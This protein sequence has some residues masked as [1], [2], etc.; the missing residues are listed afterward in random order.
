MNRHFA[1]IFLTLFA[2]ALASC[3]GGKSIVPPP[4]DRN[5][6]GVVTDSQGR[7]VPGLS[8]LIDGQATGITTSASGEFQLSSAAFAKGMDS[9]YRMA[10][11]KGGVVFSESFMTPSQNGNLE[12]R[13][14]PSSGGSGLLAGS[15][16]NQSTFSVLS[17][18]L[19]I[20]FANE[21]G[22][23]YSSTDGSGAYS[24]E[25][26]A[27]QW[28][29]LAWKNGYNPGVTTVEVQEGGE[30][31]QDL[32]LSPI[33][34]P[35]LPE[36][37]H[38]SGTVTDAKTGAPVADALVTMTVDTGI[39]WATPD[40]P[41]P[42]PMESG[43]GGSTGSGERE[44]AQGDSS[45]PMPY[46]PSYQETHT[47]ASGF[48]EFVDDAVGYS[49]YLSVSAEN[50]MPG[51]YTQD[52][53][54]AGDELTVDITIEPLVMTTVSGRVVDQDGNPVAGAWVEFIYQGQY[55]GGATGWTRRKAPRAIQQRADTMRRWALP[56]LPR[57]EITE[58]KTTTTR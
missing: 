11:G 34:P 55:G 51:S 41:V 15:A 57:E 13:F 35:E 38:V 37:V 29:L 53:T 23:F 49:A 20:A 46:F 33:G 39:L 32:Y 47:D 22:L 19:V 58:T 56:R 52:L 31:R 14:A 1:L 4:G 2:L 21:G 12:I 8:I 54:G 16:Y 17:D 6:S 27:G 48:Y 42:P 7:P 3:G 44:P 50:Y 9:S 25:L 26:P 45:M 40:M 5:V 43:G 10:V 30:S 18:V 28:L 24:L 36:G